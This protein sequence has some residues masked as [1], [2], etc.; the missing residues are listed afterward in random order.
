MILR[1]KVRGTGT[2]LSAAMSGQPIAML[3]PRS[4]HGLPRH[5]GGATGLERISSQWEGHTPVADG[6]PAW[7]AG[8]TERCLAPI[9]SSTCPLA[10]LGRELVRVRI[11]SRG[12]V[13]CR[14]GVLVPARLGAD[15]V[16]TEL[17][18]RAEHLIA[19]CHLSGTSSPKE[20]M[21]HP[22]VFSALI[23]S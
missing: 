14:A 7:H 20:V 2:A 21:P 4:H 9:Q 18:V 11:L 3:E 1:K 22:T 6:L 12:T 15:A 16:I 10:W 13:S 8:R 17:P 23:V 5:G 19:I